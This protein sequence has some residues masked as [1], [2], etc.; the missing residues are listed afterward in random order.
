MERPSRG[1]AHT[2]TGVISS[3]LLKPFKPAAAPP[4][5][6][7]ETIGWS[8]NT[9][10][11][12]TSGLSEHHVFGCKPF[13]PSKAAANLKR[14][15]SSGS[16]KHNGAA[17]Q[18]I[19]NVTVKGVTSPGGHSHA[20][21]SSS[22]RIAFV[23]ELLRPGSTLA[24]SNKL[25]QRTPSPYPHVKKLSMPPR[26]PTLPSKQQAIYHEPLIRNRGR[27][28]TMERINI[29]NIT[30]YLEKHP[31]ALPP[32]GST[33]AYVEHYLVAQAQRRHSNDSVLS[34]P[35]AMDDASDV[36]DADVESTSSFG[37]EDSDDDPGPLSACDAT[38]DSDEENPP[39]L[40]PRRQYTPAASRP[41]LTRHANTWPLCPEIASGIPSRE[42]GTR[43]VDD[44]LLN[45]RGNH[46]TT[47]AAS[48]HDAPA[49]SIPLP[50]G[51]VHDPLSWLPTDPS[52]MSLEHLDFP[53]PRLLWEQ[54]I[55][56]DGLW[57]LR[58]VRPSN[59]ATAGGPE[60]GSGGGGPSHT[61]TS[62]YRL[63][64][65]HRFEPVDAEW[66]REKLKSVVYWME[67]DGSAYDEE[68]ERIR[69]R[70]AEWEGG[71]G[72]DEWMGQEEWDRLARTKQQHLDEEVEAGHARVEEKDSVR[73]SE[74]EVCVAEAREDG[75][76]AFP[77]YQRAEDAFA[78]QNNEDTSLT[79]PDYAAADP[80]HD[81][82]IQQPRK[83]GLPKSK[84]HRQRA[85][86]RLEISPLELEMQMHAQTMVEASRAARAQTEALVMA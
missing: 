51:P 64:K 41:A 42:A 75:M 57:V 1:R 54:D 48:P 73:K 39:E 70:Y 66:L 34:N 28:L 63:V 50:P 15:L 55:D 82:R 31:E 74:L 47:L 62:G 38:F 9:L 21:S 61:P 76:E 32:P 14:Q 37:S 83:G 7:N 81:S 30:Q 23:P 69:K 6:P 5:I 16:R 24:S 68:Q 36:D 33:P 22:Q 80:T 58:S 67:R 20:S 26:L 40:P 49:L 84:A 79:L 78:R 71:V 43:Y 4:P 18:D 52:A 10:E 56:A 53:L 77:D 86:S 45:L 29:R 12:N 3:L 2:F 46:S 11:R 25:R 60:G 27:T 85:A 8:P 72:R 17:P 19:P 35:E 13:I 59:N 65:D 44:D